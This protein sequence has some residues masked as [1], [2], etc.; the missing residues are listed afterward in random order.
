MSA[1]NVDGLTHLQIRE[2]AVEEIGSN[3]SR[4]RPMLTDEEIM[5]ENLKLRC[6]RM[7]QPGQYAEHVE[8]AS[9]SRVLNCDF[10]IHRKS[11]TTKKFTVIPITGDDN[12]N[13]VRTKVHLLHSHWEHK[14]RCHYNLLVPAPLK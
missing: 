5:K 12:N 11:P 1:A 6:G 2:S 13:V 14:T 9:T 7:S 10:L 8:V 4:Y 3:I